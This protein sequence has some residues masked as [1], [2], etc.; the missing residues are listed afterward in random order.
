MD[1]FTGHLDKIASVIEENKADADKAADAV[2][3]YI[4]DNEAEMKAAGTAFAEEAKALMTKA[5]ENPE[6]AEEI[7]KEFMEKNKGLMEKLEALEKRME[8]LQEENP[9]L[10]DNERIQKAMEG[11]MKS[12]LGGLGGMM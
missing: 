7:Q 2:E 10:K 5:M 12:A 6:K 3:K 8:K 1:K 4:K 11:V 9:A